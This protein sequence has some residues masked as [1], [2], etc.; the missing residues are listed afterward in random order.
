MD[1][2]F[3]NIVYHLRQ[4]KKSIGIKIIILI[5]NT[6]CFNIEN[7]RNNS[8]NSLQLPA[9]FRS[10]AKLK[11]VGTGPSRRVAQVSWICIGHCF[12]TFITLSVPKNTPKEY[13]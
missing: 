11:Q 12:Q 3:E 1:H 2:I 4:C 8:F 10:C 6:N 13:A 5:L 7:F 9:N